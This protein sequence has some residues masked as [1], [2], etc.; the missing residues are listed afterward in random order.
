MQPTEPTPS[1]WRTFRPLFAIAGVILAGIAIV[2]VAAGLGERV[3]NSLSSEDTTVSV[4]PG[5]P[6]TVDI[7]SGASGERIG[8]ILQENGV[9][10]SAAEFE[11]TVRVEGLDNSLRAGSYD[12]ETGMEVSAVIAI[13]SAGPTIEVFDIT[14]R[15]GLRVTEIL[16]VLAEGSGI[17]RVAFESA[18]LSSTVTTSVT[19]INGE[20]GLSAWEG[21]LFPDT[22]RFSEQADASD[23]LNRLAST[24]EQRMDSIDWGPLE[25]AGLT[26]YEGVILA[27]LIESE[28]RVA[29]ERPIVS[30][31]LRNRIADGQR[32][33][34][35]AT[36][37]YG[38]ET[39]DPSLFN[40]ESDSPYN[41]YRVDGLP[42]TPISAPGLASLQA[43]AQPAETDFR[44]YV[45]ADESGAHA[46]AVTFEEHLA[47]VERSR[48]AGLLGG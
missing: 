21:L 6:V 1:V 36:V 33:E 18:L 7:P 17:D 10:A 2:T 22:Y 39:R 47:N 27:S 31:V 43:A 12:L 41:T 16:D 44:Y 20:L 37:L 24:M 23:I 42:P 19:D 34:I 40:N 13:L 4:E 9:V 15:E 48:A 8:E 32:L 25:S 3:G 5:L 29:D 30:S 46:F 28:V 11:S 45:L 14:I 26:R 38:L 35:D